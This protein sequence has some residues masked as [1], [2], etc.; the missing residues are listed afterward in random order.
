MYAEG[1]ARKIQLNPV[2]DLV[3]DLVKQPYTDPLVTI[4]VRSDGSVESVTF[5]RS[6]GVPALDDAVRRIVQS[7]ERYAPFPPALAG[8]YDV[9]EIRRTWHFDNAV[10]L[11]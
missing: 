2:I 1:M 4:A 5:V 9:V 3:R 6:S 11:Y 7:Q 8:Q 10:R